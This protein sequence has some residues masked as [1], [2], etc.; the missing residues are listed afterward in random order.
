MSEQLRTTGEN[1]VEQL[2]TNGEMQKLKEQLESEAKQADKD[3]LQKHVES[4]QARAEA[5][6]I[7]GK[8]VSQVE[9]H[10]KDETHSFGITREL[11]QDA[12]NR[13]LKKIQGNL[14]TSDRIFS[15]VVHQPVIEKVSNGLAKTIARPSAFLG[16]SLGALLGSAILVY[17]SRHYG[18]SYNY[19]AVFA[20]FVIGYI[21]ALTIESIVRFFRRNNS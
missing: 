19:A 20:T 1:S 14:G 2:D 4:L 9:N 11:K 17:M 6:A 16:G 3:P 7:S 5:Q 12:Y 13:T 8:E 15:K 18:F 21:T 10:A